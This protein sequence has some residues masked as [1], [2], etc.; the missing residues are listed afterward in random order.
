MGLLFGKYNVVLTNEE[1]EDR[2]MGFIDTINTALQNKK[3]KLSKSQIQ[4]R[5]QQ[6][7]I[8]MFEQVIG[9]EESF[10]GIYTYSKLE[11]AA[12]ERLNTTRN[13]FLKK[14]NVDLYKYS[15]EPKEDELKN[16]DSSKSYIN[17][18]FAKYIASWP[19]DRFETLVNTISKQAKNISEKNP[20]FDITDYRNQ[21]NALRDAKKERSLGRR[22][23]E[24]FNGTWLKQKKMFDEIDK[25]MK[26]NF[27]SEFK[28]ERIKREEK[29]KEDLLRKDKDVKLE[30]KQIAV[31]ELD[32]S[33]IDYDEM[34]DEQIEEFNKKIENEIIE[35]REAENK[36]Y[37]I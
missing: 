24:F 35:E 1:I 10:E 12:I 37:R 20:D 19:N 16:T 25:K 17:K 36:E 8:D 23:I 13:K 34:T 15:L 3:N 6:A 9:E 27:A 33:E 31:K 29:S 7:F 28:S 5:I 4:K 11:S 18:G 2:T 21:I 26:E 32:D 22:I 30:K 14:Y